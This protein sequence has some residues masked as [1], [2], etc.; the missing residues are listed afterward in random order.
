MSVAG[1][2]GLVVPTGCEQW[3]RCSYD[4]IHPWKMTTHW[5]WKTDTDRTKL[6]VSLVLCLSM[7]L[8]IAE[9][10]LFPLSMLSV[11]V[12]LIHPSTENILD[13]YHDTEITILVS[14]IQVW[15]FAQAISERFHL[16]NFASKYEKSLH[17]LSIPS[18]IYSRESRTS[19][20]FSIT[21]LGHSKL[22]RAF[23][24]GLEWSGMV[25]S[26]QKWSWK[27]ILVKNCLSYGPWKERNWK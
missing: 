6:S 14:A 4:R 12:L 7:S 24:D 15:V 23:F 20:I 18:Y 22:I 21:F 13:G 27:L 9:T 8:F 26:F 17:V 2:E 19:V 25:W 10:D 1:A 5:H 3:T 11:C 16:F